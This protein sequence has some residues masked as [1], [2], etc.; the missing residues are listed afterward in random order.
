M[1]PGRQKSPT[2]VP[3]ATTAVGTTAARRGPSS[4]VFCKWTVFDKYTNR[5]HETIQNYFF[6]F[7]A[8]SFICCLDLSKVLCCDCHFC[9][10][11]LVLILVFSIIGVFCIEAFRWGLNCMYMCKYGHPRDCEPLSIWEVSS[12]FPQIRHTTK[13]FLPEIVA[14]FA[15]DQN[16]GPLPNAF[17]LWSL[18]CYTTGATW[19]CDA[20]DTITNEEQLMIVI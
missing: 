15:F 11:L 10:R 5:Q 4:R 9:S 13:R 17:L 16:R 14:I 12:P 19:I 18:C 1:N 6:K 7:F 20:I 2:V 8:Y 3:R